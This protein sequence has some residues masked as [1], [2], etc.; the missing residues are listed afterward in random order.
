MKKFLARLFTRLAIKCGEF[1]WLTAY[2]EV[3]GEKAG[4]Q[5]KIYRLQEQHREAVSESR[6]YAGQCESA[7]YIVFRRAIRLSIK[8]NDFINW[9]QGTNHFVQGL[10]D[11]AEKDERSGRNTYRPRYPELPRETRQ[12]GRANAS[13]PAPGDV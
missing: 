3:E 7:M 2:K 6:T 4:L 5:G 12:L 1:D 11:I 10:W 13:L 8:R 9:G